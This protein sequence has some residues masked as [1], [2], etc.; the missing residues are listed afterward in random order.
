MSR[1]SR[2]S[3]PLHRIDSRPKGSNSIFQFSL[4]IV[5]SENTLFNFQ[6]LWFLGNPLFQFS[7]FN[8]QFYVFPRRTL[9]SFFNFQLSIFSGPS[10]NTLFIFQFALVPRQLP[11]SLFNFHFSICI[12]FSVNNLHNSQ[13]PNNPLRFFVNR[14]QQ[15][16]FE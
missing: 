8:S 4:C 7:L 13:F 11:L 5:P 3:V 2:L 9:F 6:F 15:E 12:G 16:L 14:I 1:T 10:A